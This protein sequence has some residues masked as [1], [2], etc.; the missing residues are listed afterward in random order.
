MIHFICVA[1][2]HGVSDPLTHIRRKLHSIV[3]TI[4]EWVNVANVS[5]HHTGVNQKTI[6]QN[7]DSGYA[8]R[9]RSPE[10][11]NRER[12]V[13]QLVNRPWPKCNKYTSTTTSIAIIRQ[14]NI[15]I[16][17]V[18]RVARVNDKSSRKTSMPLQTCLGSISSINQIAV[19]P[20]GWQLPLQRMGYNSYNDIHANAANISPFIIFIWIYALAALRSAAQMHFHYKIARNS[21]RF[22]PLWAGLNRYIA[23]LIAPTVSST[24]FK[25]TCY[26]LTRL[27]DRP[28][29]VTNVSTSSSTRCSYLISK[30]ASVAT[31]E[32]R[33][34]RTP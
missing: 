10:S 32:R 1:L 33:T 24:F 8:D 30:S 13:N 11:N 19:N 27:A 6:F 12:F 28:T 31:C 16:L 17:R 34:V 14:K 20:F 26:T 2:I 15:I 18:V 9:R 22:V 5:A 23:S 25:S 29:M 4:G 7:F 3:D 21:N